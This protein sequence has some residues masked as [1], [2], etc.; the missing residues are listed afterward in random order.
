[1]HTHDDAQSGNVNVDTGQ[2]GFRVPVGVGAV[3]GSYA[4]STSSSG[5]R[6]NTFAVGYDYSVSKRTELY[7]LVKSDH[8]GGDSTGN[9]FG[10]GIRTKF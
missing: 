2:L 9:S 4:Y 5:D 6:R 3:L 7:A 1:M 8:V 10:V